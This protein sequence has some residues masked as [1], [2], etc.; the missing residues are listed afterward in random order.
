VS[1]STFSLTKVSG[2]YGGSGIFARSLRPKYHGLEEADSFLLDPHKWLFTPF[3]PKTT[4]HGPSVYTRTGS[5]FIPPTKWEGQSVARF[6]F[7]HPDTSLKL[8]R[9]VLARTE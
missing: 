2:A 9:E 8:V 5:R 1:V 7:P 3:D 4:T 6:A